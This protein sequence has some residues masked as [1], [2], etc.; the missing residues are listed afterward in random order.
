MLF[1]ILQTLVLWGINPRHWL[2]CYLTACAENGASAP[3]DIDPFV[4]WVMDETRRN[5]LSHPY[6]SRAPPA[7]A[8]EPTPIRDNA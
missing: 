3:Q 1:A 7:A 6:P 8:A 2:R 4:P 5:A